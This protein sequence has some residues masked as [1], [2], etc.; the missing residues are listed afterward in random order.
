MQNLLLRD[1]KQAS[2]IIIFAVSTLFALLSGYLEVIIFPFLFGWLF[3]YLPIHNW[4]ATFRR[5]KGFLHKLTSVQLELNIVFGLLVIAIY[6]IA[7]WKTRFCGKVWVTS[8]GD[9]FFGC[10]E[11]VHD[12]FLAA[13]SETHELIFNKIFHLGNNWYWFWGYIFLSIAVAVLIAS[14]FLIKNFLA[15]RK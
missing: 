11:D 15:S 6:F 4:I 10:Q 2:I 5:K 7:A 9:V 14:Y 8:H 3:L 13:Q 1:A 12:R